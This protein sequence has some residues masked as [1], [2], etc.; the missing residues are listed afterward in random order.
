MNTMIAGSCGRKAARG[1]EHVVVGLEKAVQQ[2][3]CVVTHV[4]EAAGR[5]NVL[6]CGSQ[7][8]PEHPTAMVPE[9][10]AQ[11]VEIPQDGSKHAQE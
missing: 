6:A 2:G 1:G 3:R 8:L 5:R 10:H 11:V 9:R 7:A 4:V